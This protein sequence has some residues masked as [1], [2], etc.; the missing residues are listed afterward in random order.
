MELSLIMPMYNEAH[1]QEDLKKVI[2]A[3]SPFRIKFEIVV[4]NDGSQNK[5]FEEVKKFGDKRVR[6]VG[7]K[8]NRG[9][10]SALKYGFDF[11]KGKYVTFLDCGSDLDAKSIKLFIDL[12]KKENADIV[13]GSKRHPDSK[14]YY[15]PVRRLMSRT[16]QLVNK[17]LFNLNVRDTQV[18]IKLFKREVLE[19]VLPKIA[20]KKFAFD[21]ELLVIANKLN[22][23]IIEAPII[24]EYK[25]KST[26]NSKAV[27]WMIWDTLAIWYRD[28]I[29]HYYN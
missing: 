5:C 15:P 8:K 14:V 12:L 25:F 19:K 9:K 10:G 16:Y 18:G 27:F 11:A 26:I 7:Y 13:I 23:K 29:L 1:I 3:I 22:Y 20:I 21:L 6:V 24:L 4:V 28:K 2:K 17:I